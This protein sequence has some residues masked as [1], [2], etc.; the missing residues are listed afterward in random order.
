[1]KHCYV[2]DSTHLGQTNLRHLP[3]LYRHNFPGILQ[4]QLRFWAISLQFMY[5]W[6]LGEHSMALAPEQYF[7][8]V[9]SPQQASLKRARDTLC[10]DILSSFPAWSKGEPTTNPQPST[11]HNSVAECIPFEGRGGFE[12]ALWCLHRTHGSASM[13]LGI[14]VPFW[15]STA[16]FY[17][18]GVLAAVAL[19]QP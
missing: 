14:S 15:I 3:A 17:S 16:Y 5:P 11:Q 6:R 7:Q 9:S 13:L 1:M 8:E 12:N 2:S 4:N 10:W 19:S 18:S